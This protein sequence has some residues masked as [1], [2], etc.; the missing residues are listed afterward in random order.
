MAWT[1]SGDPSASNTDA[2]R[3]LVGDIDTTAQLTTDEA[4]AWE[5]SQW[6]NIYLAAASVADSIAALLGRTQGMRA[7]GVTYGDAAKEMRER[8][9]TLRA[10]GSTAGNGGSGAAGGGVFVGGI[11]IADKTAREQDTDRVK[12]SFTRETGAPPISPFGITT[13]EELDTD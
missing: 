8:A 4:I 11:S 6:P 9:K 12:P 7:D 2:V 13:S 10:K 5:V 1:Y 3:Y